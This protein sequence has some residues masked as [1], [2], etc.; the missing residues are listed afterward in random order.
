MCLIKM[1][2]FGKEDKIVYMLQA[3][4]LYKVSRVTWLDD[5]KMLG[6]GLIHVSTYSSKLT[7]TFWNL[8]TD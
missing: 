5:L 1:L 7:Y 2:S 6:N 3:F 8:A 4:R